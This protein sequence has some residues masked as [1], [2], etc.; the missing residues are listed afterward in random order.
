[1][2]GERT[3]YE[4]GTPVGVAIGVLKVVEL[5]PR[6]WRARVFGMMFDT[7]RSFLLPTAMP[8]I[9]QLKR[10]Y[11]AHPRL[12]VLVVGH[13]DRAG[14][15]AHNLT[16]SEER[17]DAIAAF[18]RDRV[19]P[20]LAWYGGDRPASKRWGAREDQYML[21]AFADDTGPFAATPAGIRRFQAW[22]GGLTV[23]GVCG[24]NT[25]R[26]LIQRY[27]AQDGTTLPA[28]AVITT[29]G[30]G[31]YHPEV[32]TPDGTPDERNRRVELFLFE[33]PPTPSPRR[34]CPSGGC[35]EHAQ[36]V[37]RAVET[38]DL[39]VRPKVGVQL[40]Y[41][42]ESPM[43]EADFEAVFGETRVAGRTGT[44]G[45]AEIDVPGDAG[46]TFELVLRSFPERYVDA[47]GEVASP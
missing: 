16:L 34:P 38:L 27:M 15:D 37:E 44:D 24:P 23:D 35:P 20:W 30:C 47:P 26:E 43:A 18:L 31:E 10:F 36:W 41:E 45:R 21:G 8:A 46:E 25:R 11:D 17:A 9:R 3:R 29:H 12:D 33:G 19:D 1:M 5:P 40:L 7:D 28:D 6:A 22:A 4:A 32:P 42:D 13:A 39:R 2:A 14:S